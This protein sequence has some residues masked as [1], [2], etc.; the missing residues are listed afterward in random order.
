[1]DTIQIKW[2][3]CISRK[4]KKSESKSQHRSE[5]RCNRACCVYPVKLKNLKANHNI[6]CPLASKNMLCI[7]RK[8]KKSESKSQL[9]LYVGFVRQCCVYPVKLKNLKAN[10]NHIKLIVCCKKLC[11][12][13]KVKKSE[14]KSQRGCEHDFRRPVVY[15]P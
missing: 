6:G 1:M 13:R 9:R 4:V 10:H 14:S 3:L 2:E 15:I 5:R 8:V 7:S 12:S 11:I